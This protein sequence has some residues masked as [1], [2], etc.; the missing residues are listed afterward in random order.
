MTGNSLSLYLLNVTFREL[1]L[2]TN[3]H[4]STH[5]FVTKPFSCLNANKFHQ[6]KCAFNFNSWSRDGCCKFM[7]LGDIRMPDSVLGHHPLLKHDLKQMF[8]FL[9]AILSLFPIIWLSFQFFDLD[10]FVQYFFLRLSFK[11]QFKID[12]LCHITN[13]K[14]CFPC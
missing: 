3:T 9:I 10:L 14:R 1:F 6:A 5:I 12:Y 7:Q 4:T 8:S 2:F 13:L 11:I